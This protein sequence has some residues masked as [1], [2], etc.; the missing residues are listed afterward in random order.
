[1]G[2]GRAACGGLGFGFF[3]PLMNA[4]GAGRN[5][6]G[7]CP[8][9]RAE[10]LRTGG[11][12]RQGRVWG[13]FG[14]ATSQASVQSRLPTQTRIR[15]AIRAS[16]FCCKTGEKPHWA[17][18]ISVHQWF[19]L[20]VWLPRLRRLAAYRL[21]RAIPGVSPCGLPSSVC[22]A[23]APRRLAA[24]LLLH[25]HDLRMNRFFAHMELQAHQQPLYDQ[26][27]REVLL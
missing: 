7:R 11:G 9:T 13:L 18:P 4:M 10:I 19:I 12:N 15:F 20:F 22:R 3:E 17:F 14:P 25:V 6:S 26:K 16:S 21:S 27:D 23:A 1:M 8:L 2:N 24:C 5:G